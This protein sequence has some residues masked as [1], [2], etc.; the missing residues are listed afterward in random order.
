VSSEKT[1]AQREAARAKANAVRSGRAQLKRALRDGEITFVEAIDAEAAAGM[2]IEALLRSLEGFGHTRAD[3]VLDEAEVAGQRL[4]GELAVGEAVSVVLALRRLFAA[5]VVSRSAVDAEFRGTR[6]RRRNRHG[7]DHESASAAAARGEP[8]RTARAALAALGRG[9]TGIVG[10]IAAPE[11]RATPIVAL[12]RALDYVGPV[13]A[14]AILC[15]ARLEEGIR[16]G[17]L[18]IAERTRLLTALRRRWA[19]RRA[20][21]ERDRRR[22]PRQRRLVEV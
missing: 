12:V 1:R 17:E 10:A 18:T 3:E 9:E 7:F 20:R 2:P 15:E 21:A 14:R 5:G 22:K 16:C 11:L 19:R 8:A 13:A 6:P 4:C